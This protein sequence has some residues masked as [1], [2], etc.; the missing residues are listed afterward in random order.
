MLVLHTCTGTDTTPIYPNY[1]GRK[2]GRAAKSGYVMNSFYVPVYLSHFAEPVEFTGDPW[3]QICSY[4]VYTAS[5]LI[6]ITIAI[7]LRPSSL[8]ELLKTRS[9][10]FIHHTAV[11]SLKIRKLTTSQGRLII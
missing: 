2:L 5:M 10:P 9:L 6:A 8:G 1:L 3:V 11:A 7:R 4:V